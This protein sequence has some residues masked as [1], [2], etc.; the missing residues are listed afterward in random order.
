MS[1]KIRLPDSLKKSL[2]HCVIL[3]CLENEL[4]PLKE[5]FVGLASIR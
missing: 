1:T 5:L 3:K 4:Q 2:K